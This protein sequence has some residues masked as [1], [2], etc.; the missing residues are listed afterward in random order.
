LADFKQEI[1]KETKPGM[2]KDHWVIQLITMRNNARYSSPSKQGKYH[3]TSLVVIEL[4]NK[5]KMSLSL[6]LFFF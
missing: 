6:T 2:W 1:E 3:F 5:V 4:N